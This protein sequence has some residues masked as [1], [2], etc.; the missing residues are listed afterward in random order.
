MYELEL[1]AVPSAITCARL[2]VGYAAH[3]WQLAR[4]C[5]KE[6][7]DVADALVQQAILAESGEPEVL[8]Y[9]AFRLRLV[10]RAVVVEVWDSHTEAPRS[11]PAS[12]ADDGGYD[13]PGR[14]RRVMWC[15]VRTTL[16]QEGSALNAPAGIPRRE[17]LQGPVC[18]SVAL[19]DQQLLQ[20]VLNGLRTLDSNEEPSSSGS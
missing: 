4:S 18:A 20:R 6:L 17:R 7:G 15:A 13:F 5:E 1:V 19:Q 14:G 8:N 12:T 3:K 11:L 9:L 2:L 10:P 16:M